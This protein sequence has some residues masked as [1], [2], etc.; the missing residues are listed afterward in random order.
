MDAVIVLMFVSLIFV[1]VLIC[2]GLSFI[3]AAFDNIAYTSPKREKNYYRNP[4]LPSG[5]I[6]FHYKPPDAVMVTRRKW[7]AIEENMA[8]LIK[9]AEDKARSEGFKEAL[10]DIEKQAKKRSVGGKALDPYEVLGVSRNTSGSEIRAKY[11]KLMDMYASSKFENMDDSFVRLAKLHR[12][13]IG[14]AYS[15]ILLTTNRIV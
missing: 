6:Y 2:M 10:L 14:D 12:K 8:Y 4:L 3:N 13:K 1:I 9:S 11:D 7:K 15:K 5:S